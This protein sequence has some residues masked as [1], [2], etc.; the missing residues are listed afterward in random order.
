MDVS[1]MLEKTSDNIYRTTAHVP[2]PVMA[3]APTRDEALEKLQAVLS[4]RLASVELVQLRIPGTQKTHSWE[5][6]AGVWRDHPDAAEVV[7]AI[8]A[9]RR[10][11]DGDPDRL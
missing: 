7:Q 6:F 2:A 3:E 5:R 8:A 10:H 9:H 11:V 4:E 1:V